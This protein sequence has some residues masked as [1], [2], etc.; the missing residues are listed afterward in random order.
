MNH[1]TYLAGVG[2]SS[3]PSRALSD[4]GKESK[5][6]FDLVCSHNILDFGTCF[7]EKSSC[8]N[9]SIAGSGHKLFV[10]LEVLLPRG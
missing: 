9:A 3:V 2:V 1:V 4:L 10:H 6:L 8:N 7:Q 5:C